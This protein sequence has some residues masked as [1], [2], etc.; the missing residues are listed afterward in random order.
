MF[1]ASLNISL[2]YYQ[3]HIFTQ[4]AGVLNY[5]AN[6]LLKPFFSHKSTP[7]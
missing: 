7:F 5:L 6:K 3:E 2:A 4:S 1:S